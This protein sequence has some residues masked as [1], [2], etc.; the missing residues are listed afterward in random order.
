MRNA[1]QTLTV[2]GQVGRSKSK[3]R[4]GSP[5]SEGLGLVRVNEVEAVRPGIVPIRDLE[6]QTRL[7]DVVD[8]E[9]KPDS[10]RLTGRDVG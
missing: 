7:R 1:G 3:N 9:D 5:F 2:S 6:V 10:R 8:T 4:N